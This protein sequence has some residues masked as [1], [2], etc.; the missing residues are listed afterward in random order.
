[1]R[2]DSFQ[3][4]LI[5]T[6]NS[7][8]FYPKSLQ[9]VRKNQ[10]ILTIFCGII[11]HLRK[12]VAGIPAEGKVHALTVSLEFR[13]FSKMILKFPIL[14]KYEIIAHFCKINKQINKIVH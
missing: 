10:E 5:F 4:I 11:T 1:M 12:K 9:L 13:Q 3:R 6:E 8:Q 14:Q 2:D 7:T